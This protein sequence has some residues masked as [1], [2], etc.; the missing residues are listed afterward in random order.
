MIKRLLN[1]FYSL[2]ISAGINIAL[3]YSKHSIFNLE[4]IKN[5]IISSDN[6]PMFIIT[7]VLAF[8]I[9]EM[10]S[11]IKTHSVCPYF[12]K[13]PNEGSLS[14]TLESLISDIT[15]LY[16]DIQNIQE[17]LKF[18]ALREKVKVYRNH[19]GNSIP[20]LVFIHNNCSIAT[21]ANT[22]KELDKVA[23]HSIK[24]VNISLPS[25]LLNIT[26]VLEHLEAV[27]NNTKAVEKIRLQILNDGSDDCPQN[28]FSKAQFDSDLD[29]NGA[30]QNWDKYF[31]KID[32]IDY[33]EYRW[34]E[35][36]ITNEVFFGDFMM[37]DDQI[38]LMYD[39][40]SRLLFLVIGK[41]IVN[42][43]EMIFH[44]N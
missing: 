23:Q 1:T 4:A 39:Y 18:E 29:S 27:N 7:F 38:I 19:T 14:I 8:V 5:Y 22:A 31:A 42:K 41:A 15:G 10:F 28:F 30:K 2:L 35:H 6:I 21:Y 36:G 16:S 33:R 43:Y 12:E 17:P 3:G 9:M 25:T 20:S 32:G 37:Y 26:S 24:S 13:E 34:G 11:R 40:E 44:N